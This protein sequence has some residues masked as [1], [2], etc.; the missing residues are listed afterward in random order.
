MKRKFTWIDTEDI[1][2]GLCDRFP[3]TDP[4][5]IRFTDLHRW[6]TELEDFH[7]DPQSLERKE[8]RSDS[9]GVV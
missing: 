8:T 5:T 2:I 9:D 4:L 1:A 7:D 3:D 6:T